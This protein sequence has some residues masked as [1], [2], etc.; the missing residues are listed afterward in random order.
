MSDKR[1][2]LKKEEEGYSVFD[3]GEIDFLLSDPRLR[4]IIE[5]LEKESLS[6]GSTGDSKDEEKG[7]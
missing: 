2:E 4:E 3:A 6:R 5:D 1:D 7:S